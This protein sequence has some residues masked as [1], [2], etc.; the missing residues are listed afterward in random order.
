M[1]VAVASGKGGTG[2][3]TVATS[4]AL[5]LGDCQ[6]L[7]CDVEEPNG[8]IFLKPE[9]KSRRSVTIPVPEVDLKKCTFCG[10][11]ASACQFNAI[12]VVKEK[13]LVF[14]EL[15]HG[16]GACRLACPAGAVTG[17]L[18]EVGVIE[19]G[20]AGRIDFVQGTLNVGEPLAVPVVREVKKAIRGDEDVLIDASPGT[21]CP[22]VEALSD[23]DFAI[24]V[25]E[26][27]PFGLHDLKLALKVVGRM[28]IPHGVVVNKTQDMDNVIT[29]F[30][31]ER[32]IPVLLQIPLQR[33]IAVA[34]SRGTP[35]VC[36]FPE[37]RKS[38]AE[39]LER[40]RGWA[41]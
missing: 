28:A 34:Y 6:Y 8:Y 32:D 24:L 40:I 39:I 31:R 3:T 18:R 20:A 25:T 38:F 30:C 19:E 26:P 2:K 12:A 4:L 13:V 35:L 17:V 21:S 23:S 16:C 7:D 37:W 27:T 36:A 1:I 9:I 14:P 10:D 11:C 41:R 5:V 15:C 33:E 29:V 22:V